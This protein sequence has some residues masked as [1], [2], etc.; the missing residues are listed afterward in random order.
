MESLAGAILVGLIS[1]LA[2]TR[3]GRVLSENI[4]KQITEQIYA[5]RD[6]RF[7]NIRLDAIIELHSIFTETTD[8]LALGRIQEVNDRM[9]PVIMNIST[10][11]KNEDFIGKAKEAFDKNPNGDNA[12]KMVAAALG[13]SLGG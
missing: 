8:I 4:S 2:I 6:Q 13:K 5:D 9:F 11:F 1:F 10:L 7:W 3:Q 12:D